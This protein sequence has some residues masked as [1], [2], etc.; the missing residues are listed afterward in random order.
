MKVQVIG[1]ILKEM[2]II[3]Q[4]QIDAA[5]HVQRV[6]NDVLGEILVKLNFITTDE[7]ARAI[8]FQ[9]KLEYVDL[10]G[11]G[12]LSE[13]KAKIEADVRAKVE[14]EFGAK[15][16]ADTEK[17]IT[18][19]IPQTLSTATAAGGNAGKVFAGATPLD[20]IIKQG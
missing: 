2:G 12:S 6:T 1:E 13:Y 19:A 14:A 3:P 18:D 4:E 16:T 20:V 17:A 8:A 7:L 11:V 10:D 5:M 15:A 9:Y